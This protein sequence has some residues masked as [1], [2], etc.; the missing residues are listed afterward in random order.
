MIYVIAAAIALFLL[1]LYYRSFDG[2][3]GVAFE[4]DDPRLLAAKQKARET[5]P[6]FWVAL[7]RGD[8]ADENFMLKFNLNH[9]TGA[10]DNESIWADH[11]AR[12]EGRIFGTLANEPVNPAYRIDQ[13]VE[14][15][16][17]AIDDWGFFRDGVA[18]G[19]YITRLMIE[20]A[21][22]RAAKYYKQT[23]GWD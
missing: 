5:L 8:P 14:I 10:I 6:T 9:G 11:L 21:P 3:A 20:A 7:E 2:G 18:Q 16:P 17:E 1:Y 4:K 13:E 15:L 23:M 12:R 22:E 19:N